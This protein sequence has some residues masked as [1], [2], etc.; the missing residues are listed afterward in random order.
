M[1][2]SQ[3][4]NWIKAD[5]PQREYPIGT[6]FKAITGGYW[7][8]VGHGFRWCTGSTFPTVGGDWDGTVCL[9]VN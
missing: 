8:R 5:K 2:D 9:P 4:N 7:I 6:M 3:G 1:K